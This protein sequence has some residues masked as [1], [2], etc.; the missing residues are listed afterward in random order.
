MNN[1]TVFKKFIARAIFCMVFAVLFAFPSAANAASVTIAASD[2]TV[3]NKTAD[4]LTRA[5]VEFDL[6]TASGFA[7]GDLGK[8][9]PAGFLADSYQGTTS[10]STWILRN[11][12]DN[13]GAPAKLSAWADA[14]FANAA[15]CCVGSRSVL[16]SCAG[17]VVNITGIT[18]GGT[19]RNKYTLASRT[20]TARAH[21][22]ERQTAT[23]NNQYNYSPVMNLRQDFMMGVDISSEPAMRASTA[24]PHSSNNFIFRNKNGVAEDIY[25][26]FADHG[27]NYVRAR[28]WND[29]YYRGENIRPPTSG[30]LGTADQY[31]RFHPLYGDGYGPGTYGGGNNNIDRALEMGL[32]ST[33]H[34]MKLLVNFHYSD[35][36]GDPAR[37]YSPKDWIGMTQQQKRQAL[38][39][40]TFESLEKMV[41]AGVDIGMVQ[42]GNETQ[43]QMSGESGANFY[44]LV[45]QGC[46]AIDAINQK[47]GLNIKKSVHFANPMQN[48]SSIRTWTNGIQ[49]LGANLDLVILSW[50]PE[51]SSHGS[52]A[53]LLTLMNNL[54]GD[55]PRIEVAVAE[56]DNRMQG[57]T[58]ENQATL[59]PDYTPTPQGQAKEL[60]DVIAQVARVNGNKGVGVFY[61]EPAWATPND[62]NSRRYYG[63][64]W[65]SRYSSYYDANN[66]SANSDG[67]IG[68]AQGDKN[69]FT[70]TNQNGGSR[71]PLPSMD[72]WSLVYGSGGR[73]PASPAPTFV[74]VTGISGVPSTATVGTPLS[75][76][77]TVAPENATNKT[78]SWSVFAA[79]TTGATINGNIFSAASSGTATI[80]ATILNGSAVGT[81]FSRDFSVVV[82]AASASVTSVSIGGTA[83]IDA[84]AT[85]TARQRTIT[86]NGTNLTA[87]NVQVRATNS[88]TS[89]THQTAV[90]VGT[91]SVSANGTSATVILTFPA[92]GT[93]ATVFYVRAR[94]T[95]PDTAWATAPTTVT[96]SAAAAPTFG[97]SLSQTGTLVFP[98]Q[99]VGYGEQIWTPITVTNTGN[100]PTG[101]LTINDP[102]GFS[103]QGRTRM[104][105]G[106][107]VNG[108]QTFDVRPSR[109]SPAGTHTATVI[110][111]G[112]N[113]ISAQFNVSFT[114]TS[115]CEFCGNNP[116]DCPPNSLNGRLIRGL[117]RFDTANISAWSIQDNSQ[118]GSTVY[119]DRTN[120]YTSLPAFLLG[121]ERLQP[122]ANARTLQ[123]DTVEFFARENIFVYVALDARRNVAELSWLNSW[124]SANFTVAATDQTAPDG[125]GITYNLYRTQ[126]GA[127][128]SIRL[129]T[130]GPSG[131]VIMYTVFFVPDTGISTVTFN[132]NGGVH[133]GSVP[134]VQ[135]IPNGTSAAAPNLSRAG[136]VL[137]GWD[138]SFSN[139][140]KNETVTAQWLRIGAVITNGTGTMTSADVAYLARHV[141]G[142]TNFPLN[143]LRLGN[144]RGIDR[145]V[146]P[147]DITQMARWL[148]GY[149]LSYL[150]SQ[151]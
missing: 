46:D 69:T 95:N 39:D 32:R 80:R 143:D 9:K 148:V 20:A 92:A 44:Q 4:G 90:T 116:C 125:P 71:T 27:V 128:Q 115:A 8:I 29:P 109:G 78:I 87:A 30:T 84:T 104:G 97:I 79:G 135:Q 96:V 14:T 62:A 133:S 124:Q 130:N 11:R 129:G 60:Y 18:L 58:F 113:G 53:N 83:T 54:V 61:W 138:I 49:N 121:A 2:I 57:S 63:T 86:V 137:G 142:H 19:E 1:K 55:H 51:Y 131:S 43:G 81:N 118:I 38:Y 145:P 25:K 47:Y 13:T 106:I 110:V 102:A 112:E 101:A 73:A 31:Q 24:S 40:F 150:I 88:A 36:W 99:E 139:I 140:T 42:V 123:S 17:K 35:C 21:I 126:L 50:Y 37:Q 147:D 91:P 23:A 15:V 7:A 22:T 72:V 119:G 74:A 89:A 146:V 85:G 75:L 108:T 98:S 77:G 117:Q 33:Q 68:S 149:E 52:L 111:S 70:T 93:S 41:L 34:G 28:I 10:S 105:D 6:S 103:I 144:L 66:N 114:V 132:P 12:P 3:L 141:A 151:P 100:Q 122:A 26:I 136:Y 56:T 67:G 127:N 64:G 59:F 48:A 45:K 94:T 76:T 82:S 5:I 65:A 134:L 107:L 16:P 120:V